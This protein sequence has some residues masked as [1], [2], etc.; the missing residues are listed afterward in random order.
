MM[1]TFATMLAKSKVAT[2]ANRY[3]AEVVGDIEKVDGILKI[4]RIHVH[5]HLKLS[6]DQ[7]EAAEAAFTAYLSHCPAA[8]SVIAA[9]QIEHS[10]E[11]QDK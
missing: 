6:P 10:L 2:P 3:R 11:M 8:Q 1:G 9:I 7:R 4:T 5:Y